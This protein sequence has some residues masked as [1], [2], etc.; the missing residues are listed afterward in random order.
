MC[1]AASFM[2]AFANNVSI[3]IDDYGTDTW[4]DIARQ[5]DF[6]RKFNRARHISFGRH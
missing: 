2:P 3:G 6:A 1:G 5:I 4:I